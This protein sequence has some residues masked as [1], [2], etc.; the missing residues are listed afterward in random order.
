MKIVNYFVSL[1]FTFVFLSCEIKAPV[2]P[3]EEELITTVIFTL[4][5]QTG[6]ESVVMSFEDFDGDGGQAPQIIGGA[7][8]IGTKYNGVLQFLDESSSP[9]IDI[10]SEVLSEADQHQV[11]YQPSS[12]LNLNVTYS[13]MD[14]QGKPI[15]INTVLEGNTLSTGS[16]KV[17]L[18]HQPNKSG[19]N[20]DKGEIRNAGGET[21]IEVTFNV[22]I[23]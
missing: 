10:T 7:L 22:T 15:G 17:I 4:T 11:F 12:T 14:G 13:D 21:D 18:K 5:P 23:Q 20:V 1:A 19:M 9:V 8:E 16:L 6:G 3:N 2:V